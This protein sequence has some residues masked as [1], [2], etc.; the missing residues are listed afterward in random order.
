MAISSKSS[1]LGLMIESTE[2]TPLAP[3][4]VTKFIALQPDAAMAP[5]TAVLTNDEIRSSIGAAKDILGSEAP[6]FSMSAYLRASG[7][8]GQAP[9]YGPLL[10]SV[11]GG[12]AVASTEYNTV[13][14]STTTVVKV[15]T[16]EGATFQ[17]GEAL[18]IKDGTN[19]YRIRC[20]DSISS[21]DLTIGFQLPN[22]PG[23]G[24]NL[25]KCS[26]YYPANSGHPS[27][28]LFHYLGNGGATQ[29]LAGGR[30]VSADFSASAGELVNGSYS[31]EGVAYYFNPIEITSA[32]KYLDFNDGSVR[33]AS[34]TAKWYKNPEELADA[35]ET[36][37][38]SVGSS[39]TFTVSYSKTT[40]KY[41]IATSGASLSLL[42]N[43]G[44]NAANTIGTKIGFL[45][46]A[47]D[48]GA[49]T[50]TSDNALSFAAPYTPSYDAAD[51]VAAKN[52]EVMV[53]D[54]TD[55][56]CF[57]ASSISFNISS[58]KTNIQ[59]ICAESG[60][61]GSVVN[62]RTGTISVSGLLSQYDSS[63]YNK[64]RT[65]DNVK[66]QYSFG[67]KSGGNWTPGKC[68]AAYFPTCTV[69]SFEVV[70]VDGLVGV[71]IELKPYV[72]AS[73]EGECFIGFV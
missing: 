42:W 29:M 51:P 24:V 28:S 72:N 52:H 35:I 48:T 49:L 4:G 33:A 62:A 58:P 6:T 68:G 67:E 60:I 71:N 46:A 47:N 11:F 59:S 16:G 65:G 17:R 2:G 13:A 66:F 41:T 14:S 70:D 3:S 27:L 37:M 38:N 45:V 18:L 31:V 12:E 50:Y 9:N 63:V 21:D 53:G 61:S 15:D 10:K 5:A 23:T 34:V 26:L 54:A 40:G 36:A 57:N 64:Y 73:G 44:T 7:V 39:D 30:T 56:L 69:S 55:Y 25:G 1:V 43:T 20:I 32:T 19:G 22:A 8:E